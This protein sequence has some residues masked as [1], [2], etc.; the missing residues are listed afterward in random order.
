MR[1]RKLVHVID[2]EIDL[3]SHGSDYLESNYRSLIQIK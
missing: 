2:D 3:S 1:K